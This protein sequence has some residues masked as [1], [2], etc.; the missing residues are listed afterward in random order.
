M[1]YGFLFVLDTPFH[2]KK[3]HDDRVDLLFIG[4]FATSFANVPVSLFVIPDVSKLKLEVQISTICK[5][6]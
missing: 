3:V 2:F 6:I 5:K 4:I 1:L